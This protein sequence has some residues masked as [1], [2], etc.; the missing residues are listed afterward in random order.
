VNIDSKTKT[1]I[2]NQIE[3]FEDTDFSYDIS[4]V[5]NSN[6]VWQQNGDRVFNKSYSPSAWWLKIQFNNTS[7]NREQRLLEIDYA[8]LDYLDV[9]ID[10][11]EG[12]I[13]EYRTGDRR[14]FDSKPIDSKNFVFPLEWKPHESSTVYIRVET[15]TAVQV[16]LI[17]WNKISYASHVANTGFMQGI[18]I[19]GIMVLVAYNLMLFLSLRDKVYLYYVCFIAPS[20]I[21]F[22]YLYGIAPYYLWRDA[23]AWN[24]SAIP[25]MLAMMLLAG[26][27]FTRELLK[28]KTWTSGWERT[29]K[30]LIA[31]SF[32]LLI[33]S[34][35][36]PY[37]MV[38]LI[39]L[40]MIIVCCTLDLSVGFMALL[41]KIS[42]AKYYLFAW[43]FLLLGS[44]IF[45]LAKLDIL[46]VSF[47]TLHSV[48]IGSILEAILLSF[49][50][51]DRINVERR[52]RME[53]QEDNLKFQRQ[54]N[55]DLEMRVTKRT[56]E[57]A[58]LN[59]KL[60]ELSNTDALTGVG[61]RRFLEDMAEKEWQRGLRS[62]Q[63]YSIAMVDIDHFKKINDQY[64]H[65]T[66]DECLCRIANILR[67]ATRNASDIVARF[68]GEEFCVVLPETNETAAMALAERINDTI[69]KTP[70]YIGKEEIHLTASL[71]VCSVV[72][73]SEWDL[74]KVFDAADEALYESKN[75]GRN[76]VTLY[77]KTSQAFLQSNKAQV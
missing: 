68:G 11:S 30:V 28:L 59:K 56:S 13:T 18:Y 31:I 35:L 29:Y 16:P 55:E 46:S 32:L 10:S 60:E 14:P 15:E 51:A 76:R 25:V 33:A 43:T 45:C 70:I 27:A 37:K 44:V 23:I 61:N 52:L 4:S 8:I 2:T 34:F 66:G 73:S 24:T 3:Y 40:V 54:V 58:N 77:W 50:L 36:L 26:N 65:G 39:I 6:I 74:K 38:L 5:V 48:Q 75:Q 53:A 63:Y 57:L 7:S 62:G 22:G 42:L 9:F 1:V 12:R 64:G 49:A 41:R 71:G 67:R 69:D 72:P 47:F 19:G 17:L 20:P 21:L